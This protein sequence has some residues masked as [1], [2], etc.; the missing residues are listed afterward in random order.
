MKL[1]KAHIDINRPVEAGSFQK[2]V[3]T[4]K[5]GHAIDDSGYI[6]IVF[7][8][9][10]DFGTPQFDRP[11]ESN[12]CSVTTNANCRIEPRWDPKGHTRPWGKALYL[13]VKAGYLDRGEKITVVFG[14][15]AK[16]SAGW[17]VQTFCEKTFEFKTLVDP[18]ATYQ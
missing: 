13:K 16:G 7:R 4:F 17:Q 2:M 11:T 12:Y 5:A 18:F 3:Y 15:T 8:Y 14:D 1:G 10:G 9:A 6:K